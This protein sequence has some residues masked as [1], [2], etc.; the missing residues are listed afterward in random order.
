M[1]FNRL[2][3][4]IV[5][6]VLAGCGGSPQASATQGATAAQ[7]TP[8]SIA[9][10]SATPAPASPSAAAAKGPVK[11]GTAQKVIAETSEATVTAFAYRQPTAKAAP[12][13]ATPDSEWA[14]ADVQVCMTVARGEMPYVNNTPWLLIYADGTT[15]EAVWTRTSRC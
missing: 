11:F 14:S 1:T 4:V 3:A 9:P 12:K 5:V 15:A 13:P 6:L 7:A 10:E 8:S 2:G